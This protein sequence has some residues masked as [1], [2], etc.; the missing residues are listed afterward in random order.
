MRLIAPPHEAAIVTDVPPSRGAVHISLV[1][2]ALAV[3]GL[4]AFGAGQASASHVSCGD[5]ITTDATL[6]SDL[7]DCPN[8][9]ILIGADDVTLDLNGHLIAG[10]ATEF[11]GCAQTAEICDA[12]VAADGRN[13]VTVM[14]GRVREF[15]VGVLVGTSGAGKVRN[16]RVLDVSSARNE[17]LGI[18]MFSSVRSVVE[19]SSAKRSL[20][21]D[22]GVGMALSDARHVRVLNSSFRANAHVGIVTDSSDNLIKGNLFARNDDEGILVESGDRNQVERNRFV[23]N[24]AGITLGP[25]SRNVIRENHVAGGR[26]GIRIEKGNGNVVANN[27][28]VGTHQAGIRLGIPEPLLGGAD[29]VVRGNLVKKSRGDGFSVNRKDDHSLL[30]RNVAIGAE[31]DGFDVKSTTTKLARNRALRNGDLGIEAVRG[32]IDGGGNIARHNADPRQCT[33]IAC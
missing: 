6:D 12:G 22:D 16:N 15:A 17:F 33:N 32:V 4:V 2:V 10:D 9:G 30:K 29:N 21:P 25:G 26:D 19:D 31:D 13:G 7:I 23:R 28:V 8:N 18:G 24:G 3:V 11:A 5:T 20:N 27:V 14:H 1:I